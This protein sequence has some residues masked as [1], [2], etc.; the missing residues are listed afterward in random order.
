MGFNIDAARKTAYNV[1]HRCQLFMSFRQRAS[2][3]DE[4][5]L[6]PTMLN[7]LGLCQLTVPFWKKRGGQRYTK[8]EGYVLCP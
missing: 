5:A 8:V 2:P 4:G 1:G 3:C 6:V 7:T